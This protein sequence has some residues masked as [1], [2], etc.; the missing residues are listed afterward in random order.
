MR[1]TRNEA[2]PAS[3]GFDEEIWIAIGLVLIVVGLWS[4]VGA[5]SLVAPGLVVLWI[6]LPSRAPFVTRPEPSATPPRR[7]G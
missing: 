7:V 3:T 4:R 6:A 5:L 2:A 1:R